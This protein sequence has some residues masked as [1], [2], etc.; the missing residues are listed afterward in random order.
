MIEIIMVLNIQNNIFI[1]LYKSLYAFL[2]ALLCLPSYF[3]F[4]LNTG[5]PTEA[6]S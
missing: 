5:M 1:S 6:L 3:F 4:F 2:T